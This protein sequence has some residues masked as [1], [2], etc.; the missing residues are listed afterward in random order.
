MAKQPCATLASH[1]PVDRAVLALARL[2]GQAAARATTTP[3]AAVERDR[4][5]EEPHEEQHAHEPGQEQAAAELAV[6]G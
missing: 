5:H 3:A 2:L 4:T 6:R 1:D